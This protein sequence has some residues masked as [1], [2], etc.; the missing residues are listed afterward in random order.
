M[1]IIRT[2]KSKNYTIICNKCLRDSGIS[3]RA[4][5]IFAYIMTLPDDWKIYKSELHEH[6]KEG[7]DALNTAFA[8]LEEAGYVSK[9]PARNKNGTV[10]G[11]D[12]T[13]YESTDLLE[14]RNTVNPSDGKSATTKYLSKPNTNNTNN[15][16]N[17]PEESGES[18][19]KQQ[20]PKASP[21]PPE[22]ENVCSDFERVWKMYCRKGSKA[23]AVRYW[24]KLNVEDRLAVEKAI[25]AYVA[26]NEL[27]YLKNFEGWINPTNRH[28]EDVVVTK[29]SGGS[30]AT[31]LQGGADYFV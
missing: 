21:L 3:A 26:S 13:V 2:E 20:Q 5:G 9:V 17:A 25:P 16:A 1:S 4:K 6:F 7:R 30:G 8:E 24:N 22:K 27:C 29:T 10:D 11:W 31:K 18:E 14:N 12:Y 28:W 19:N 15:V 23:K